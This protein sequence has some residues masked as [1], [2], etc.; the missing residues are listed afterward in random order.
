MALTKPAIE[1]STMDDGIIDDLGR[2][3]VGVLRA[4]FTPNEIIDARRMVLDRIGLMKNTRPN[5]SSRHLAGFHRFPELEPLHQLL[6][7]NPRTRAVMTHLL[8]AGHRTIG[9]S[10]ITVNRSQQWHKDL[11]RGPF[12]HHLGE[13]RVC[14]LHHGKVFK[15]ILYLQDSSSLHVV[16]GSHVHDISLESD[17]FA[18]P[19]DGS[20]VTRID[21]HAGDLV[22]IDI[23]TTHRGSPEEAYRSPEA[24]DP[25]RILVSTVFGRADCEFTDRMELGN[26][27]R[28]AVWQHGNR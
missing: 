28:L 7:V 20:P 25:P 1:R 9:L 26:A 16:P 14:E 17:E 8:G 6:T 23:C 5:A 2:D 24:C 21:T 3:G 13:G 18:V 10:D 22:V 4:V 11:L 15:V 12:R 19:A 27:E